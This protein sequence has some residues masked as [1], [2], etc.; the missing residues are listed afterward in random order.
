MGRAHIA[1]WL[2]VANA[3]MVAV[4]DTDAHAAAQA[5]GLIGAQAW[6]DPIEAIVGS[7]ADV[8]DICTPP[9]AHAPI[10]VAAFRTGRHVICEPPLGRSAAGARAMAAAGKDADRHLIPAFCH[11]F[12][13]LV[14]FAR[15]LIVAGDL[16]RVLMFRCRLS[17]LF[18][19]AGE[20][21]FSNPEI[22]GGGVLHDTGVHG[23]DLFR[24]LVG[25]I[26]EVRA[27][28]HTSTPGLIVEDSCALTLAAADGAIGV[29]EASWA[30]PGGANVIEVYGSSGNCRIDYD[31]DRL[32]YQ[33]ADLDFPQTV[34]GD[35]RDRVQSMLLSFGA[36][37][38]SGAH[39]PISAE[40]GVRAAEVVEAA[41][42]S[43]RRRSPA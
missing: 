9:V 22:S 5:A 36:A 7:E 23:I 1:R 6:A 38:G 32:R 20:S 39:A 4:C 13:P 18:S 10:A 40:D 31:R 33:T 41:Y 24:F 14:E 19:A 16:G 8:V 3:R 42:A 28:V 29:M 2:Q 21:W 12:H 25:E 34:A 15:E 37:L 11:R 35:G 30:T 43:A 27:A 26:A 17:G